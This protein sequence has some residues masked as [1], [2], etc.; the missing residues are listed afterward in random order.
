MK[1][2]AEIKNNNLIIRVGG[3]YMKMDEFIKTHWPQEI[4]KLQARLN[5]MNDQ[6]KSPVA[7]YALST[8]N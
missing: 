1:I 4:A 3:G 7:H 2:Y 8:K 6:G 5:L